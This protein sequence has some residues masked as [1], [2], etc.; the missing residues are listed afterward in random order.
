MNLTHKYD[1]FYRYEEITSILK[2]YEADFPNLC[3]L[4]AL[5]QTPEGR[6]IWAIEITNLA[7]GDFSEKPAYFVNANIHCGEVTG[8]MTAMCLLDNIFTNYNTDEN[9]RKILDN[10]TF[11]VIPRISPDGSEAY[12]TTPDTIRSVNRMYPY[13]DLM[14]GLQPKDMDGDGLILKMRVKSPYGAWKVSDRD[15]R[16]MTKRRPD[17]VE[18]EFYNVYTEGEI[19]DFDGVNIKT[20]PQ[21]WGNDFNRNFPCGWQHSSIQKGSGTYP[22]SNIETKTVADFIIGHKNICSSLNLH[23]MTG[24][25]LYPPGLKHKKDADPADMARYEAMGKIGTEESGYP[26][27]CIL[28]GYLPA[29]TAAGAAVGSLDDFNHFNMGIVDFTI[30]CWD[31]DPRAGIPFG[32]PMMKEETDE[33]AEEHHLKYLQWIDRENDG[34]G[35]KPW[36]KFNHPQLGEVEIGGIDYKHVVQNPPLKFLPQEVEKHTRFILRH[37]KALPRI[38]FR[39]VDTAKVDESTYKIDAY[40]MNTGFLPTQVTNEAF[41]LKIDEALKVSLC[42]EGLTFVEGKQTQEIGQLEGYSGIVA[43]GGSLGASSEIV[44]PCEKKVTW[45]VKAAPGTKLTITCHNGKIGKRTTTVTL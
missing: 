44:S 5:N 40:V 18:G 1:H 42:G 15:P 13:S 9:I 37:V 23:T 30:E 20:A 43:K 6:N 35:A 26:A 34:E 12:L 24:V 29:G 36:T 19:V 11:Y 21:K 4:T 31:L 8:S 16:L 45:I 38:Q 27:V 41:K 39:K 32:S 14:P 2:Q 7:T 3:R 28:D 17:D 33:E 25:Y 10:Y 22:L